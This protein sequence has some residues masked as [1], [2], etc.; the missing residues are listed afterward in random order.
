MGV[1]MLQSH[2]ARAGRPRPPPAPRR[3]SSKNGT[4]PRQPAIVVGTLE[5]LPAKAVE[6][7]IRPPALLIVGG[8]STWPA[9]WRFSPAGAAV[10]AAWG[11]AAPM[12]A[13]CGRPLLDPPAGR[14]VKL[15]ILHETITMG[16]TMPSA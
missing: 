11:R 9:S 2:C 7:G 14:P 3:P 1:G 4:T 15:P 8:W 16:S 6:A 12:M 5:T 13:A 10:Q